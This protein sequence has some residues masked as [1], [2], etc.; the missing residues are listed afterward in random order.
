MGKEKSFKSSL[1]LRA[2]STTAVAV[3]LLY[4]VMYFLSVPFIQRTVESIEESHARTVLNNVS[5][6]VEKI[7]QDIETSR[8]DIVLARKMGL[9]DILS[10]VGSRA[11]WLEEQVKAGKLSKAQAKRAL[12]DE[13]RQL[14][15]GNND[16]VWASNYASV[17]VSHP[18]PALDGADFS[19]KRDARGNLIVPPMVAIAR[20]SGDGY[21]SYWWRRLGQ[22][23][24]V[25]KLSY[26]KHFPFFALVIGTGVYVDEIETMLARRL[27]LDIDELR[28]QLRT[29]RL[30]KTGYV[31]VFDR[32]SK[33]LIHPNANL[34]GKSLAGMI[35]P[36]TRQ[37][38]APMLMA[39]AD[40]PEGVRYKWDS[41]SDPGNYVYDKVS[42]VRYSPGLDWYIGSSAYVD[43]FVESAR[44]LRNR[45]L[46]VFAMTLLLS[47]ALVYLFVKRL[48][49]P[50]KQLSATALSIEQGDLDARC[51]LQRDDE[52]GVVAEAFNGMVDR[53]RDSIQNLDAKVEERTVERE[54]AYAE[55]REAE[56]KLG[57]SEDYNKMLFQE[58]HQPMVVMDRQLGFV[59]CNAAAVAVYGLVR[60][61]DVLGKFPLDFSTAT[62][63]DGTDSRAAGTQRL[64]SAL[65]HGIEKFEWRHR[66]P[67]GQIWDAMV[68]LMVFNY[69]GR[70]LLQFTLEDITEKKRAEEERR[71]LDQLKSDFLSSVSHE[72]RTP[73]TSVVGFAK[74]VR[75]KLD[76]VILPRTATDEKTARTVAQVRGNLDIIVTESDRLSLLINNVLDSAKLDADRVEWDFVSLS[77]TRLLEHAATVVST[78]AAQKGLALSCRTETDLPEFSGDEARLLQVL[79]NLVSNAV[80]FTEH[81]HIAL[82]AEL[83]EGFIRFGVEDTGIGIAPADRN[84]VFDK[85]RQIGDTL[86]DKPEGSGLGLSICQQII[87]RHG[88]KIWVESELGKGS[89][90]Y[91]TIPVVQAA[92]DPD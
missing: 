39:A 18:D 82:H 75:K 92:P 73:I 22:E 24:Q 71:K 28:E 58:S 7:H 51:T 69:R 76:E 65:T 91:F 4:V 25:E 66:R 33:V 15:Y 36:V 87:D 88:G 42:W 41:P 43:E 59:D 68:S 9:R 67:D 27:A 64:H 19:A 3:V 40:R 80:K 57:E 85:F 31:Y 32:Q 90:F 20:A 50:L 53:L 2:F 16:Y 23:Q 34:E 29:T 62:Q 47:I 17:L 72:L 13:L 46:G 14:H 45:M 44:T 8:T 10:V 6:A 70:L 55:R 5:G 74:L 63:Y 26:F 30:A 60:R 52:I 89:V 77:A 12:L 56:T 38:L 84:A 1:F 81:G 48:V 54:K 78:L 21:H 49:A 61:E 37:E 35:D 11:S 79:I 86:T 83:R